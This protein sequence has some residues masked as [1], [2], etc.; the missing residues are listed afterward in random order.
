MVPGDTVCGKKWWAWCQ[1][2][3]TLTTNGQVVQGE[4]KETDV[5]KVERKTGKM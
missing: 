3:G 5:K 1:Y 4:N 2:W